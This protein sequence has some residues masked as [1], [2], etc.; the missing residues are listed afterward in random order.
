MWTSWVAGSA[1]VRPSRSQGR[2]S[3]SGI[4]TVDHI[5]FEGSGHGE[6]AARLPARGIDGQQRTVPDL[7]LR[8]IFVHDPNG[9]RI[10]LNYPASE[11]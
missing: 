4:G 8:Q 3:I 6:M 7:G 11:S 2:G 5:A 9:V 1:T 10:E